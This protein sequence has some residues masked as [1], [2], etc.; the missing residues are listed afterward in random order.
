MKHSAD[1]R[2]Y[3]FKA[4]LN[5]EFEIL[6]MQETYNNNTKI[7]TTPH[8]AS[9]YQI[10]WMHGGHAHHKIDFNDVPLTG[11]CIAFVSPNQVNQFD[12]EGDYKGVGIV[13]TDDFYCV[14]NED[15]NFLQTGLL[16]NEMYT[17]AVLTLDANKEGHMELHHLLHS[18]N[19]EFQKPI[20]PYQRKILINMLHILLYTAERCFIAEGR[21]ISIDSPYKQ[22]LL[23]FTN[24]L[25]QHFR[26]ERQVGFYAKSLNVTEKQIYRAT[27][28]LVESTPKQ[29]IQARITLEGKRLLVHGL[30]QVNEIAW[31]LGFDEPTNFIK[32]FK[33]QVGV[34]PTKFRE[35]N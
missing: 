1:I 11:E 13:F 4:G 35:N 9:F 28:Q 17:P 16:F 8:R 26:R 31:H 33:K 20:D 30:M 32:F 6:D 7:M 24:L 10:L 14:N 34:T 18:M 5:H 21:E 22:L 29:L 25:N 12:P 19:R 15:L 3:D 23:D 2:K 27:T